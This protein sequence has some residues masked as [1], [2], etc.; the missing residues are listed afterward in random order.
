MSDLQKGYT[1][2]GTS[3][4]NSV[5]ADKLNTLVDGAAILPGFYTGKSENQQAGTGDYVLTYDS[6]AAAYRKVQVGN[7]I[8]ATRSRTGFRNLYATTLSGPAVLASADELIL[9]SDAGQLRSVT[10]FIGRGD[11][12]FYTGGSTPDGR[13]AAT[14]VTAGT[15]WYYFW[16]ISDGTHENLLFSQS[17]TSPALPAGYLYKA[18]LGAV[19]ID[20]SGNFVRF[21]Q[22]NSDV[23]VDLTSSAGA[24]NAALNPWTGATLAEFTNIAPAVPRTLQTVDLSR[25]LPPGLTARVTGLIGS[26]DTSVNTAYAICPQ[27]TS[28]LATANA[29]PL[30][31]LA[32]YNTLGFGTGSTLLGFGNAASF[33]VVL[34]TSQLLSWTTSAATSKHSMRITGYRLTL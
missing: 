21:I 3:P 10:G 16:A 19:R 8:P 23:A 24:T 29:E 4:N 1:F 15:Q 27:G 11:L 13:D 7:L 14:I 34:D 25:C 12:R 5:T 22:R 26:T 6:T 28:S 9:R 20:N 32:I 2:S 31:G 33:D 18:L 17:A 30:P